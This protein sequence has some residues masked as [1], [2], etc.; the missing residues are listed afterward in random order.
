MGMTNAQLSALR[1]LMYVERDNGVTIIQTAK[2]YEV[3]RAGKLLGI[4]QTLAGASELA[5]VAP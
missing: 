4:T 5:R 2:G 3:R 1:T